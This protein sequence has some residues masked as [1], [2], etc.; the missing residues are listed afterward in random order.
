VTSPEAFLSPES[1][2]PQEA[3]FSHVPVLRISGDWGS[4][5]SP[6]Y[7]LSHHTLQELPTLIHRPQSLS[8]ISLVTSLAFHVLTADLQHGLVHKVHGQ[9]LAADVYLKAL[10]KKRHVEM[11]YYFTRSWK[12]LEN[13]NR[14]S[15]TSKTSSKWHTLSIH[16]PHYF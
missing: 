15:V 8:K 9:L 3:G 1:H 16:M 5:R 4:G 7:L 6:A 2:T 14:N 12:V 11:S 10:H 13:L